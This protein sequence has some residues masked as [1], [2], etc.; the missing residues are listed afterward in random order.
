MQRLSPENVQCGLKGNCDC[1]DPVCFH[2]YYRYD[3]AS[4]SR[5]GNSKA[6]ALG[7]F[8]VRFDTDLEQECKHTDEKL[9]LII[10]LIFS[11]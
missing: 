2:S 8:L 4:E 11:T 6:C 7:Y 9:L 3:K 10:L 5:V 1:A